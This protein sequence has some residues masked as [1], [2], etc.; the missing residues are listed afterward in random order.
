LIRFPGYLGTGA[1]FLLA[2]L[3]WWLAQ[4]V[5]EETAY[6]PQPDSP[7][8]YLEH[9]T[10]TTMGLD[11]K[12]DKS[13]SAERMIHYPADDSTELT[14]PRMTV[15][16]KD[17]PPWRI[18][19]ETGWVSGDREIILLNGEVKIDRSAAEEVRPLHLTTRNLRVQPEQNYAETDE[20]VYAESDNSWVESTGMQAWFKKPMRIKLLAKVRGRYEVD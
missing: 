15:F 14:Q 1:A 4:Q 13:L 19:S 3:T 20:Y 2:A 17:R 10:A 7:D 6:E 11:G 9:F 5:A 8:F 18:Q 12:P 16:D